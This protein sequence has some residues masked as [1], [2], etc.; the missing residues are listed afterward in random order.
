M[1]RFLSGDDSVSALGS[2]TLGDALQE[3]QTGSS[4]THIVFR[5]RLKCC[6]AEWDLGFSG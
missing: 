4:D 2:V 1:E 3:F 6:F 5:R